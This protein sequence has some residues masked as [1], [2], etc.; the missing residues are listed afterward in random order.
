MMKRWSIKMCGGVLKCPLLAR[1]AKANGVI[2]MDGWDRDGEAVAWLIQ[3]L[4]VCD[5]LIQGHGC[6]QDSWVFNEGLLGLLDDDGG[7][8]VAR[9]LQ[10][11]GRVQTKDQADLVDGAGHVRWFGDGGVD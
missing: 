1:R 10:L 4:T 9:D 7:S 11:L 5:H 6:L 2:G 8:G 3:C